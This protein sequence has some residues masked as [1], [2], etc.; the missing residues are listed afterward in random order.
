[1][2]ELRGV[3]EECNFAIIGEK[4]YLIRIKGGK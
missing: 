3:L 1:M 2:E 4:E